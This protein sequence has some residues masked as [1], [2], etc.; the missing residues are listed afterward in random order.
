[1]LFWCQ[2]CKILKALVRFCVSYMLAVRGTL[3]FRLLKC[4]DFGQANPSWS[5]NYINHSRF[6]QAELHQI[7]S[8]CESWPF[9]QKQISLRMRILLRSFKLPGICSTALRSGHR[10]LMVYDKTPARDA[11]ISNIKLILLSHFMIIVCEI[12]C[13]QS[14]RWPSTLDPKTA[15]PVHVTFRRQKSWRSVSLN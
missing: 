9:L 5:C 13:N 10:P 1:M 2:N 8:W 4:A 14:C 6:A 12:T 11:T 7:S 3:V 15:G